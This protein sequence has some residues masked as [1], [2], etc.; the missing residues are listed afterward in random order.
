MLLDLKKIYRIRR[1]IIVCTVFYKKSNADPSVFCPNFIF[2]ND[3]FGC[4][5]IKNGYFWRMLFHE[6]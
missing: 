2:H 4:G 3:D 6:Q 5:R 1:E